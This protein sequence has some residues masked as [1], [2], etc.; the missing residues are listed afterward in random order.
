MT[1]FPIIRRP[2][3]ILIFPS[4]LLFFFV[5]L[6][7]PHLAM[8]DYADRYYEVYRIIDG[9]T[10]ELTDGKRVRLIGI[11]APEIGEACSSAATRHLALLIEGQTVYLE[12]DVS[13]TDSYGRL[14]RYVYIN[15]SFVNYD[16][17]C[18]GYAYAVEYPPDTRYAPQ[19]AYAEDC[20]QDN[21]RGCLWANDCQSGCYVHIT[22]TGSKYHSAGCIYLQYSDIKMCREDAISQ[23]YTACS[24]CGGQCDGYI[25]VEYEGD[26]GYLAVGCFI[27][28]AGY[29]L[30]PGIYRVKYLETCVLIFLSTI[31]GMI[32]TAKVRRP[33]RL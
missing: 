31:I 18:H 25:A 22:K 19:L 14:L 12:K 17:V 32:V 33:K 27:A 13:E 26:E 5:F 4:V 2:L 30:I 29:R 21:K 6:T 10:F 1:S 28:T 3:K 11:D 15:G 24:V 7:S 9:D 16:L 8:D 20:A 23:G